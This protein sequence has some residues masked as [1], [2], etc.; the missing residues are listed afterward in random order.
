M[1]R[2]P[3]SIPCQNTRF[4]KFDHDSVDRGIIADT[5]QTLTRAEQPHSLGPKLTLFFKRV[6][7]P[8]RKLVNI[9]QFGNEMLG[10]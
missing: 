10:A 8:T 2:E 5:N 3:F 1:T 4:G 6:K 7:R 9:L